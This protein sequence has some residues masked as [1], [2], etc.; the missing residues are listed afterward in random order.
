MSDASHSSKRTSLVSSVSP[1]APD[2]AAERARVAAEVESITIKLRAE[3][4]ERIIAQRLLNQSARVGEGNG[5]SASLAEE[6]RIAKEKQAAMDA[7]V[8]QV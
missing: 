1:P 3:R 6:E 7:L 8:E 2:V 5:V 4:R